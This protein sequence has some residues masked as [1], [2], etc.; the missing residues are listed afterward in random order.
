M[1]IEDEDSM[2]LLPFG[3]RSGI[4]RFIRSPQCGGPSRTSTLF[5]SLVWFLL[6]F[7]VLVNAFLRLHCSIC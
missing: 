4:G 3:S 2:A 1:A 6:C 7:S 5:L